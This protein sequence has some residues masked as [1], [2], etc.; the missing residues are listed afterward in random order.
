M[1]SIAAISITTDVQTLQ[2]SRWSKNRQRSRETNS[3]QA[4]KKFPYISELKKTSFNNVR[5]IKSKLARA[6]SHLEFYNKCFSNNIN[7]GNLDCNKN[8]NLKFAGDGI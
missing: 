4:F 7:P 2:D 1:I 8:F 3:N 6:S 5:E